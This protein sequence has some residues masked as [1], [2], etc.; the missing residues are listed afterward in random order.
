MY[1]KI[2][3]SAI[4]QETEDVKTF[5]LEQANGEPLDYTAG[6]FLTFI[7]N[8]DGK[9]ERRSYSFSSSPA[10][11]EEAAV[12][13]KRI[14]NGIYSRYF[15]D[16]AKA[17]DELYV[18]GAAGLF[19]LP[20]N[21]DD[22]EQ[23]FFLAAGI[24]IT[25]VYSLIKT[26]LHKRPNKKVTLIYSNRTTE[27]AV[28]HT[29]LNILAA[30]YPDSFRIEYLYSSSFNLGRARLS[31][32]LLPTLLHEYAVTDKSK[33]LFYLCG[34]FSYMRM[35]ILSLEEQ[36]INS[37]QIKK[38]NFN[39]ELPPSKLSIPPDTDPHAVK[40]YIQEKEYNF[41]CKYPDTILKAAKKNGIALP[42]SCETGRCGSCAVQ[43][44]QG[45]VWLSYNEVLTEADQAKGITLTCTGYPSGGDVTLK[46]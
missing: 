20:D 5:V 34:P 26:L 31:K 14:P 13:V 36:G 23:L 4:K 45:K 19:T 21:I 32:W 25:P 39:T 46:L 6:Q 18:M 9:E 15:I 7:F 2:R 16:K 22:Y 10:I 30:K 38:E 17:G 12:T 29:Q 28:F 41:I 8:Q 1:K 33:M 27:D 3:I 43:C 37:S 11:D 44:L 42:Y 24:G 35:V 40:L